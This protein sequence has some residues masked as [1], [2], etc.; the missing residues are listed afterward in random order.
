MNGARLEISE[1]ELT[2]VRLSVTGLSG[3]SLAGL[4]QHQ[5]ALHSCMVSAGKRACFFCRPDP[6]CHGRNMSPK[7]MERDTV[8]FREDRIGPRQRFPIMFKVH[9]D[10]TPCGPAKR[11]YGGAQDRDR[12]SEN[13]PA[14][15]STVESCA[16]RKSAE[17]PFARQSAI[18]PAQSQI[19]SQPISRYPDNR[20]SATMR[21]EI[22]QDPSD[23]MLNP[24]DSIA[25][26][27][28]SRSERFQ[29]VFR[30]T[31]K[32]GLSRSPVRTVDPRNSKP[33]PDPPMAVKPRAGA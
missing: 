23:T 15:T 30:P 22:A 18:P 13:N 32:H 10:W 27:S 11:S 6:V 7:N 1:N 2:C 24:R 9:N 8:M 26:P 31:P 33:I 20:P 28:N 3:G 19:P 5:V 25:F 12:R 21:R 29:F 14:S 16:S 17:T 4:G